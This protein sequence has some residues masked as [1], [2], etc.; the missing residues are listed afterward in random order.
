MNVNHASDHFSAS[1]LH[2]LLSTDESTDLQVKHLESCEICQSQLTALAGDPGT[3][4]DVQS[5]LSGER[6]PR[7]EPDLSLPSDS[8]PLEDHVLSLLRSLNHPEMLG[9]LG[10]S[11][12]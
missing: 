3:W 1:E 6:E 10:R 12:I 8:T 9:R 5:F 4:S 7:W 11:P 2:E